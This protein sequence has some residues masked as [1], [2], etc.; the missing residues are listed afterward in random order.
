M[1]R[2]LEQIEDDDFGFLSFFFFCKKIPEESPSS[3]G[4][5]CK[6][7]ILENE[8]ILVFM[9]CPYKYVKMS[10]VSETPPR[11]QQQQ[12]WICDSHVVGRRCRC[13]RCYRRHRLRCRRRRRRQKKEK[14]TVQ[15]RAKKITYP[16]IRLL[17][18]ISR[19]SHRITFRK[20]SS[21][22]LKLESKSLG[23]P[24]TFFSLSQS[25]KMANQWRNAFSSTGKS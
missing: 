20:C 2:E 11:E 17:F 19:L 5:R 13:S 18:P 8:A 15:F 9:W 23:S 21:S 16:L 22:P 25:T 12:H 6:N 14:K 3:S 24:A 7:V 4:S 1:R 10:H